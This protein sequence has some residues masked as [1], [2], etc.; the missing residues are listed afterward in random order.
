MKLFEKLLYGRNAW[1]VWEDLITV[2]ACSIS[3]SVDRRDGTFEK[4]EKE[5]ERAIKALGGVEVPSQMFGILI[6][7]Y[8]EDPE[9]DFLGS[10]FMALELQ[11]HWEGQFFTPYHAARLAADMQIDKTMEAEIAKKGYI[12]IVDQ[13]VGGAVMLIAGAMALK[14]RGI[15]YQTKTLFIGQD[16]NP[17]VAKMTYIQI[18]ITGCAGYITQ[19]DSLVNPQAGHP[20]FPEEG[21]GQKLWLT[22]MFA[23][24]AWEM[25]RTAYRM[26]R[27]MK[28]LRKDVTE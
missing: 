8:N 6:T 4:R 5:Y 9:Q 2:M 27:M 17:T 1:Q 12:I 25:R 16:I 11:S 13:T 20:L 10:L 26:Q 18:S 22:P 14:Q 3:N 24:E 15:N 28:S 19:G 7:A 21:E 23:Q